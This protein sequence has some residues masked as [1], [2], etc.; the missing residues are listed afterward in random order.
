MKD[1]TTG[2]EGKLIL[3]F[4]IP[5]LLGNVFQQMYVLVDRIVVGRFLG[6]EA[7]AAVG[8]SMSIIFALVSMIIGIAMAGTIIISQ[9]FGAKDFA[10]V[11][12][13]VDTINVFLFTTGIIITFVGILFS[14]DFL[15]WINVPTKILPM[16]SIFLKWY[17]AGIIGLLGYNIVSAYLRGV[18]DSKNPLYFL[19]AA[20]II[21]AVLVFLFIGV[22]K[23][24]IASAAWATIIAQTSSFIMA[25]I[26]LRTKAGILQFRLYNLHFDFDILKKAIWIGFPSG[27][28]QTL[29]AFGMLAMQYFINQYGINVIAAYTT[30]G[31]IEMLCIMPAMNFSIALISFTG[32]NLGAGM[33]HRVRKGLHAT[34]LWSFTITAIMSTIVL[35]FSE[36]IMR[37]FITNNEV[38]RIGHQY[39]M[40][41]AGFYVVFSMM[42]NFNGVMRGAGDTWIPMLITLISLWLI[43]IPLAYILSKMWQ[44][45]GIFVAIPLSWFIGL[46]L[47]FLY[48]RFGKWGK[49]VLVHQPLMD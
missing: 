44:E 35:I 49:K 17:F 38:I 14:K 8:S 29:V 25:L 39:L 24:G 43:R 4:A 40:I 3:Q 34:Q 37:L 32:Q 13:S 16:A 2:H 7:L 10:S 46:I 15:Q 42:F 41:V 31:I 47:A 6:E 23:W 48:Y 28:Q 30:A 19:I 26:Y 21:N 20:S 11:R 1:L 45:K 36:P 22:F 5:M 9:Y 18:G 33:I 27:V 12:K